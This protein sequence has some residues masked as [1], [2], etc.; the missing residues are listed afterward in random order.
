M[1]RPG[2]RS[3]LIRRLDLGHDDDRG[4]RDEDVRE[5]GGHHPLP[6]EAHELVHADARQV[7]RMSTKNADR[8]NALSMNQKMPM[9]VSKLNSG[10][11]RQRAG[12]EEVREDE[13][14]RRAT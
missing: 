7:P 3:V 13:R 6:G 2:T 8:P 5:R 1:P 10:P 14:R 4:G 12:D 11:D 9:S